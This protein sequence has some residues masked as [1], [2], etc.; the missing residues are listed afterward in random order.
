VPALAADRLT[1]APEILGGRLKTLDIHVFGGLLYA[2]GRPD[3]EAE[4]EVE[5]HEI[6]AIDLVAGNFYPFEDAMAAG[7]PPGDAAVSYTDVGGRRWSA[8]TNQRW[9]LALVDPANY[10][11]VVAALRASGGS[12][13]AVSQAE[14]RRLA[15]KAL[16]RTAAYDHRSPSTSRG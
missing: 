11:S 4:V 9:V 12:P 13:D 15:A 14:R 8:A 3:H 10:D 1:A 2:R 7:D 5:R 6:A 16:R